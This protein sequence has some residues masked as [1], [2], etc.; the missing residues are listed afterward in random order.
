VTPAAFRDELARAR[1]FTQLQEIEQLH[2]AGL[3]LGGSL[4]NAVVVDGERV[5]NPG[6]LR[7]ADEFVRHKLLDAVGDLGLAGAVLQARLS[8]HRPG[9]ALNNQLLHALFADAANWRWATPT[10]DAAAGGAAGLPGWQEARLPVAAAP[11]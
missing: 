3:A 10:A 8:A 11:L 1:T 7:M 9:H 2:A 5:M 4:E 6:G